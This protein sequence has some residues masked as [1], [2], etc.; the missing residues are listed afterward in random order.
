MTDTTRT[1]R[2]AAHDPAIHNP[3]ATRRVGK[4]R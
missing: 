2:T 1:I 4:N 3:T